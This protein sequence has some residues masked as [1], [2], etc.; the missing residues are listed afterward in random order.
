VT[1]LFANE[2][3]I[4]NIVQLL[5]DPNLAVKTQS[6]YIIS[7]LLR[8]TDDTFTSRQK[9]LRSAGL[10]NVIQDNPPDINNKLNENVENILKRLGE[11]N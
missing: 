1:F 4:K 6:S 3:L 2:E 9:T 5:S 10:L 8:H 7:N 11:L